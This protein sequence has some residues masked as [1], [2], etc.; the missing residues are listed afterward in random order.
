MMIQV[1]RFLLLMLF[2][3]IALTSSALVVRFSKIKNSSKF[4]K[5]KKLK[6]KKIES[7]IIAFGA[8]F[9]ICYTVYYSVD[10]IKQ[11][12]VVADLEFVNSYS[13]QQWFAPKKYVF[14][15]EHLSSY[16]EDGLNYALQEGVKYRVTYAPRTSMIIDIEGVEKTAGLKAIYKSGNFKDIFVFTLLV[17]IVIA[18]RI[19]RIKMLGYKPERKWKKR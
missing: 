16:P 4:I 11:D 18:L 9:F 13:R 19:F 12:Y 6:R 5:E 14:K 17:I 3:I 8:V 1:V 10:L 2:G 7:A 15:E